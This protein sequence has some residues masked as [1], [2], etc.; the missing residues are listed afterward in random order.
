MHILPKHSSR[1]R[2]VGIFHTKKRQ[3]KLALVRHLI[4]G[5]TFE[6]FEQARIA[7]ELAE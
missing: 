3:A 6:A 1:L 5:G 2:T 7:A 4:S